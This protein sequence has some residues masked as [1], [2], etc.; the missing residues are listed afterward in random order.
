MKAVL[1]RVSAASVTV[2]GEVVGAIG[3]GIV[4]LLAVERGDGAREAARMARKIAGLRLFPDERGRMHHSVR[5][6]E[7]GVLAISQF[8]LAANLDKGF[9]P[10]FDDAEEPQLARGMFDLFC[11]RLRA[12]GVPV[13]TGRF[14]ADM[15]VE[16]VNEGPVTFILAFEAEADDAP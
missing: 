6:V 16:L 2:A 14:G 3:S 7:G 4:V 10:S 12:E 9:R 11:Q 15:R 8:T 5:D 13:A 1:Q